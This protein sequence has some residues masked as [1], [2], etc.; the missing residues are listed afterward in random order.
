MGD[1]VNLRTLRKRAERKQKA[2]IAGQHR[3]Q[4]GTPK[5]ERLLMQKRAEQ[6]RRTLDDHRI[7]TGDGS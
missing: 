2:E 6:A 1:V 4:H 3:V 5:A 7:E